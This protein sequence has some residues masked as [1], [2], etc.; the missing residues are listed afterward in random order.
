MEF[1]TSLRLTGVDGRTLITAKERQNPRYLR[2]GKAQ[3]VYTHLDSLYFVEKVEGAGEGQAR[4]TITCTAH[5]DILSQ[6]AFLSLTLPADLSIPANPPLKVPVM[7]GTKQRWLEIQASQPVVLY[8]TLEEEN[9]ERR[10]RIDLPISTGNWH[11]GQTAQFAFTI[12]TG[13]AIDHRPV[14]LTID[15]TKPGRPFD[16]LG[17]NF[18]IQNPRI[19]PEVIAYCLEHLRV[20]WGRVELPWRFW[21]PAKDSDPLDSARAGKLHPAVQRAVDMARTLSDKKIPMIVTAWF[22][23]EWAVEGP[24]H[25]R[26]GPDHIWGNPL[27][28]ANTEA[29]YKSI[30]D[31]LVFLKQQYKVEVRYFSFNESDLG[32]NVRQTAREHDELIKEL[33]AYFAFPGLTTRVYRY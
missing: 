31:Y 30:A 17:G 8:D 15:V 5:A 22:P 18:R 28:H 32:I 4:I 14:H 10:L 12:I 23:P 11:Q 3:L 1:E 26:P 29:I 25:F 20:A 21:Q 6:R 27:N 2:E 9:G 24:L 13:G 33:G 16:G 7:I 19:D